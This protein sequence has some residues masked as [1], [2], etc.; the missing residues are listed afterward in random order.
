MYSGD[1]STVRVALRPLFD[2]S[3]QPV[4]PHPVSMAVVMVMDHVKRRADRRGVRGDS[5]HVQ[6]L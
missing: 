3:E 1:L 4:H 5:M 6:V 2:P